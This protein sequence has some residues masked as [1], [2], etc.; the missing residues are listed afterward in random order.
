MYKRRKP[1]PKYLFSLPTWQMRR[2]HSFAMLVPE[3]NMGTW[4]ELSNELSQAIQDVGKSIVTVQPDGGRTASGI[5]LD[6]ETILTTAR[7]IADARTIRV[8]TNQE[9]TSNASLIG[10]DSG[11]D[12][13][14]LKPE[15]KIGTPAVFAE[16]PKLA[17]GQLVLAVGR[18]WR[19][20]LVASSGI[21][22]GLMGEW[23]T[24]RG[25]KVEAFIRPDLTLYS[26]FSGGALI[27]GDH[28]IIGMN[29]GALRRGAPLTVPY[30]TINRI[31]AIL[32]EK[33]YIPRP[34][35][36]LGLQPVRVSESLKQKLNLTQDVGAL[37]VHV[38][39]DGPADKAGLLLGDVLLRVDSHSFGEQGTASVVF[40]L[41]PTKEA[42]IEGVRGGQQF[43]ST[44]LVGE[45]PRRQA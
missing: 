38:E 12:I 44:V 32:R 26:G 34:Y 36:G 7:A 24:F 10:T 19:G 11:T 35:L 2:P 14:L 3:A 20:N 37:V 29:T 40:R 25:R 33:G 39:S 43:A 42:R 16:S 4:N 5:I 21:L 18:T 28:K 8:W 23:Q 22:S 6:E 27:G 41:S 45:R 9:K 30:A 31:G 17:V 1:S 13:A 15:M